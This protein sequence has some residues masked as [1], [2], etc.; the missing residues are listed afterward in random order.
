MDSALQFLPF[1]PS[2]HAIVVGLKAQWMLGVGR[3]D[4]GWIGEIV[5]GRS[6]TV[7]G[8]AGLGGRGE[9]GR[10]AG[11]WASGDRPP[12]ETRW[13]HGYCSWD[14]GQMKMGGGMR[15]MGGDRRW[16]KVDEMGFRRDGCVG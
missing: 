5:M 9:R 3:L 15:L 16:N 1:N 8:A 6:P 12:L 10:S 14:R 7:M 11:S 4:R 13:R 2:A